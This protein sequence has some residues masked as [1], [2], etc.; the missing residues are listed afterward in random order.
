MREFVLRA[1]KAFTTPFNLNDLVK[2][3]RM[4]LVCR[5]VSN[6]FFIS[7]AIRKDVIFRAILEGPKRPPKL[8]TFLGQELKNVRP[9]EK[10]IAKLINKALKF[11]M[12]VGKNEEIKV[13]DGVFVAKKSFE[14]LLRENIGKKQIIYL[15]PE[16]K[17]IREFDF[18]KDFCFFLG[19]QK[20]LPKKT[21]KL[22]ERVGVEKVSVGKITY[23][24]S[25]VIVICHNEL[26]R[27]NL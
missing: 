10:S 13:S 19:D 2:A 6:A 5:C 15:H 4:D 8:V 20:G 22:L 1:S 9:D 16:G 21:E 25:Q 27:R 18:K 12:Y 26:D 11:G 3:G 7:E 24:A 14:E 17:D 23:L